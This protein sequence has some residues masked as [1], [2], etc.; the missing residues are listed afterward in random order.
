MLEMA[1]ATIKT[2]MRAATGTKVIVVVPVATQIKRNI[3]NN[4]S[5]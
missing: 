5:A 3:V 4:A 2:T 1:F